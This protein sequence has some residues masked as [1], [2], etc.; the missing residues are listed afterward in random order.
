MPKKKVGDKGEG[1]SIAQAHEMK[2]TEG[3]RRWEQREGVRRYRALEISEK[4]LVF[5]SRGMKGYS[6]ISNNRMACC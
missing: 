2:T 6:Q 1:P 4:N 3:E 5:I